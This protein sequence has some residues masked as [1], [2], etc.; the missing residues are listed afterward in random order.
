MEGARYAECSTSQAAA[1][2]RHIVTA[3]GSGSRPRTPGS[4]RTS[5]TEELARQPVHRGG[6]SE[7][8]HLACPASRSRSRSSPEGFVEAENRK[9][10]LGNNHN[11]SYT[12]RKTSSRRMMLS[13]QI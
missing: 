11:Y 2:V 1:T 3:S 12:Q 9:S 5:R 10:R 13:V 7:L 6:C 8:A 4:A